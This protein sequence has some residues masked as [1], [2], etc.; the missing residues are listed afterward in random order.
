[1]APDFSLSLNPAALT[2]PQGG[3]GQSTVTVV[4]TN[5][6]NGVILTLEGTPAGVTGAF[7]PTP[8]LT[9]TSVLTVTVGAAVPPGVYNLMVRGADSEFVL[10]TALRR[11]R[12]R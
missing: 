5:F 8:T 11:S 9:N 12:S 2:I 7:N 10:P 4:R 1:V 3:N 6:T